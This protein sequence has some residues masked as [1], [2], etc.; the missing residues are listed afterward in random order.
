MFIIEL[1]FLGCVYLIGVVLAVCYILVKDFWEVFKFYH[2]HYFHVLLEKLASLLHLQLQYENLFPNMIG[3]SHYHPI[4]K[5][6][7]LKLELL[8]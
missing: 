3:A 7:K 2:F 4:P 8:Q 5:G 1:F 6:Y